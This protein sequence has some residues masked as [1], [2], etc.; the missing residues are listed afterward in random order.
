MY[1]LGFTS[2]SFQCLS[3][4]R[5]QDLLRKNKWNF[6]NRFS[7]ALTNQNVR[8]T[9]GGGDCYSESLYMKKKIF[10]EELCLFNSFLRSISEFFLP[11]IGWRGQT[12]GRNSYG[13]SV[14]THTFQC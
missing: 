8:F 5:L 9:G 4:S 11:L 6:N 14:N 2:S 3:S 7:P 1:F 12:L 10:I 13:I